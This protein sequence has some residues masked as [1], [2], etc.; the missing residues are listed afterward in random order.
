MNAR[1][2]GGTALP[3]VV[4]LAS[5]IRTTPDDRRATARL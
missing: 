2:Y 3:S 4:I 1:T 5:E